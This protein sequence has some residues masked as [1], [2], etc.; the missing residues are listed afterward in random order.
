M[1]GFLFPALMNLLGSRLP[2][3]LILLVGFII[4]LIRWK[5]HPAVSI[6]MIAIFMLEILVIL[7]LNL[8]AVLAPLT[9]LRNQGALRQPVWIQIAL[10]V[11]STL[12]SSGVWVLVL[13]AIF[14]WRKSPE[15]TNPPA[16]NDTSQQEVKHV[17]TQE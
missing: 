17:F 6:L 16:E 5:K 1:Q 9:F 12:A 8:F 2:V 3:I 13:V 7:P 4:A 15:K 11:L 14:G 10:T